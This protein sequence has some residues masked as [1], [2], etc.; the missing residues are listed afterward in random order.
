MN[1]IERRFNFAAWPQV[2]A[3]PTWIDS[4]EEATGLS[5]S[6]DC[7]PN[8]GLA[9]MALAQALLMQAGA[10][11]PVAIDRIPT[12][13]MQAREPL[14]RHLSTVGAL[15][16]MPE[17]RLAVSG[18]ATRRW[19]SILG[20]GVRRNALLLCQADLPVEPP[21][22]AWGVRQQAL[23]AAGCAAEWSMLCMRIG[24][25]LLE[26]HGLGMCARM[27]L[28]WPYTMRHAQALEI[29]DDAKAWL[30]ACQKAASLLAYA[31]EPPAELSA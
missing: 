14:Q 18:E 5:L 13:S 21:P 20:F 27:R 6:R 31:S 19:D 28:A 3:H 26:P 12:W 23:S 4:L 25:T 22:R 15:S 1:D 11:H 17:L 30:D 16:L 8:A 10:T 7:G 2:W 9:E 24:L 29:D